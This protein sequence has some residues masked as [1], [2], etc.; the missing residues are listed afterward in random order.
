MDALKGFKWILILCKRQLGA[1]VELLEEGQVIFIV[2]GGVNADYREVVI[3]QG[4]ANKVE[5]KGVGDRNK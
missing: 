2:F 3:T 5:R 4:S 1:L